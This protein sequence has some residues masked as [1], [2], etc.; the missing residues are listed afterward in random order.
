[1]KRLTVLAASVALTAS[2]SMAQTP[3]TTPPSGHMA[4]FEA[5]RQGIFNDFNNFRQTILQHYAD[6]LEG[7]WHEYEPMMPLERDMAPKPVRVPDVS[8]EIP[9]VNP[10]VLPSPK[11][12]P[13]FVPKATPVP[14]DVAETPISFKLRPDSA[15]PLVGK[16]PEL[17]VPTPVVAPDKPEYVQ[18]PVVPVAPEPEP[19][20]GKELVNFYGMDIYVPQV[21]FNITEKLSTVADFAWHWKHLDKQDAATKVLE[22]LKPKIKE[23]GLN[24]YLTFEFLSAYMDSKFPSAAISPKLSAVHYLLANMGFDARI[25]VA[26]KIGE[27]IILMPTHQR[28]YGATDLV[29]NETNYYVLGNRFANIAG[30]PLATCDLPKVASTSGKKVDMLINGLNFPRKDRPFEV[31][32]D[33]MRISGSLNENLMPVVYRYPQ[34]EMNAYAQSVL[35]ANLRDDLTS[36]I[37]TQLEDK[38]NL[39]AA[40]ELLTFVQEGFKYATDGEF[41]GFEKPYFLEENLFYPKNDCEDRAIFYTYFLWN[42]LGIDNQLIQFPGH[43]SASISVPDANISGTS[44]VNEGKRYYISD[45]TYVGSTT[46][47]CMRKYQTTAPQIDYSYPNAK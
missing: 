37:K 43:E 24:D 30:S 9:I 26:T 19:T 5:F 21:D 29:I 6:F 7:T 2:L 10:I 28:I 12:L 25:A 33:N 42:S 36:Q 1:M 45:P 20:E 16:R 27:P 15:S 41:H 13:V 46:G 22:A 11:P 35:D 8:Q 40:N 34:M 39:R 3:D 4:D 47:Q 23:L 31:A 18:V 32:Y 44:Y 14:D 38:E 17:P